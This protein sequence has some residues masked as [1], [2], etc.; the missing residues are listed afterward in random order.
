MKNICFIANYYKT[1]VFI[2]IAKGLMQY[3]LRPYWIVPNFKQYISLKTHFHEDRLLY[4]GKKE[5]L[6]SKTEAREFDLKINELIHGDRVLRYESEK[7]KF[8]YLAKLK[9]LYYVFIEKNQ[10]QFIFGELT[11]AHELVAYRLTLQA[12]NLNCEYLNPHTIRI[13]N[14]RFA[15]F[16]DEFQS[17]IKEVNVELATPAST[18]IINL[19][20]PS[21]LALNN[22]ILN[23]KRT[24]EYN[25]TKLKNFIFR[26]NQDSNDPTLY[27]SAFTLFKIRTKEIYNRIVFKNFVKETK[28]E[29]LPQN[30]SFILFTLHKQPEAS[31]DV[32]GRYYENQ[33]ELITNIW[34][35]LPQEYILLVKEHS[36]AI[37][38]RS[39][40][41]YKKVKSLKNVIL[42]EHREDSHKILEK[43]EA[44]FTVSGTIAYEAALKGIYAYTFAPTFFNKLNACRKVSWSTYRN[45]KSFKE[46]SISTKNDNRIKFSDW[47]FSNSFEGIMS[48]AFSDPRCMEKENIL[49][50]VNAF[51]KVTKC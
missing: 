27:N 41:F 29:E 2:E 51:L 11:W 12:V 9:D 40:S 5:V 4:I 37:G 20:K 17:K 25:L 46:L 33:L 10:I 42:I 24:I 15:F 6:A 49:K 13:P 44:V 3:G 22:K 45:I 28:I 14:R 47:L 30:K 16:S 43:T 26:T 18:R 8:K 21:Y 36:N 38:D 31:I 50:L 35:I 23:N 7:W 39:V 1:G 19:E 48:D 32:I 34:R